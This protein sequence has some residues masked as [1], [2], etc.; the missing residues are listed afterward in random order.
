MELKITEYEDN[1][2]CLK[3]EPTLLEASMEDS[4]LAVVA[5]TP[6]TIF[7]RVNHKKALLFKNSKH[8]D[9]IFRQQS[10]ESAAY[11]TQMN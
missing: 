3:N 6:D 4:D 11:R 7:E 1:S 5:N 10:K 8:C 2:F 9:Q